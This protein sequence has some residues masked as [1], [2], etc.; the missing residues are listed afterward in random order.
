MIYSVPTQ[1]VADLWPS[2]E[3]HLDRA[4]EHHPFLEAQDV[5]DLLHEGLLRLFI[6]TADQK[7]TGFALM[8]VV[9]YPRRKVA[10][11]L[12][13]A[14]EHGFLSVLVQEVLP[15][16]QKWAKEQGADTFALT[17]RPGWVRA[18]RG[19]GFEDAAYVTMWANLDE[20]GR[21]RRRNCETDGHIR[22]VEGS[23]TLYQ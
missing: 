11:V 21:R 20:Q 14:G 13:A 5:Y 3:K 1:F 15:E 16:L 22:T 6:A 19:K 23:T 17:G 4:L 2:I 9:N 12:A 10:N 18:L 8:E 7:V